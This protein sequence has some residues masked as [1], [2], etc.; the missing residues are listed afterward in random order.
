[1][2]IVIYLEY[3]SWSCMLG[4]NK[5]WLSIQLFISISII[6]WSQPASG[7]SYLEHSFTTDRSC[8]EVLNVIERDLSK[9]NSNPSLS[10]KYIA[11][12]LLCPNEWQVEYCT[13]HKK[14]PTAY[15]NAHVKKDQ[16]AITLGDYTGL[17]DHI[18]QFGPVNGFP[19]LKKSGLLSDS[20]LWMDPDENQL[21]GYL[22]QITRRTC[23][24]DELIDWTGVDNDLSQME[25]QHATTIPSN[26]LDPNQ[27]SEL[28]RSLDDISGIYSF[29]NPHYL[30]LVL[31]NEHHFGEQ[32]YST[33]LGFHSTAL[34]ISKSPCQ[35]IL[36]PDIR[37]Y[38]ALSNKNDPDWKNLSYEQKIVQS[39]Q[40]LNKAIGQ[41]IETWIQNAST[42][43]KK[44]VSDYMD[45][46]DQ[47]EWQEQ[48]SMNVVALVFESLGIHFLQDSI[49]GGHVRI[50]RAAHSLSMA[51]Y[52]HNKDSKNGV[53]TTMG[54]RN[55]TRQF[56][57]FGDG[58]LLTPPTNQPAKTCDWNT[59]DNKDDRLACLIQYQR[60]LMVQTTSA[61]LADWALGGALYQSKVDCFD[62]D[63]HQLV[64]NQLPTRGAI[65]T[66]LD[67]IANEPTYIRR[68][69]LPEPP[70]PYSYESFSLSWSID[71]TGHATQTGLNIRF[72]DEMDQM[73]N[74]LHSWDVSL[75]S[76][77]RK[78]EA[79]EAV[80]QISH[81]FHWR[82]STRFLVNMGPLFQSGLRGFGEDVTYFMGMGGYAGVTALPEGWTKIPLDISLNYR[83]PLT[84]F[85]TQ[86]G[87]FSRDAIDKEGHWIEIALGL[88][89]L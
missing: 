32:A 42:E 72:L 79:G 51:R 21:K 22:A 53:I 48:V 12:S 84:L 59:I 4:N 86:F 19:R 82:V 64:C 88:A 50:D 77:S 80:I 40:L 13:D 10:A 2:K 68:G 3:V 74:W 1:M 54:S 52:L 24:S 15:I 85:D 6:L 9:D 62:S 83:Y 5:I 47:E 60:Q 70:P 33:W 17:A 7:W 81:L 71:A 61:S 58:Y 39:C 44:L 31:F 63:T 23:S 35:M 57:A 37:F 38:K 16:H 8:H 29:I 67:V 41:R 30:D 43:Q 75:L 28:S 89:F 34:E 73:A 55:G 87:G 49:S 56:V 25:L 46:I 36:R 76:T 11:L 26:N 45:Q 69:T 65:A 18:S 78:E 20:L 27:R 14:N 66:G